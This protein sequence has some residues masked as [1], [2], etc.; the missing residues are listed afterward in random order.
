MSK[1]ARKQN[2]TAELT[3]SRVLA[4]GDDALPLHHKTSC[5]AHPEFI[6]IEFPDTPYL[7]IPEQFRR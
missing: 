2:G 4:T 6:P 1:N 3:V 7:K 5:F